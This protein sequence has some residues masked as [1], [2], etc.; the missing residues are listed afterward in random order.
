MSE[1]LEKHDYPKGMTVKELKQLIKNW[2]NEDIYGEP[3]R[4]WIGTG[5]MLSS[6]VTEV[7][8]LNHRIEND[9]ENHALEWAD[10]ILESDA[11]EGYRAGL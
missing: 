4:V 7:S 6:I 3:T 5:T 2:P 8:P 10:I 1:I 9:I 11:F